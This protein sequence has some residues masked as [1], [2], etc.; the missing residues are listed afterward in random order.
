MD[1]AER[2]VI[3]EVATMVRKQVE[4]Q[5]VFSRSRTVRSLEACD[6]ELDWLLDQVAL[7]AKCIEALTQDQP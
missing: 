7:L 6:A 3:G 5:L 2:E 1:K 4:A